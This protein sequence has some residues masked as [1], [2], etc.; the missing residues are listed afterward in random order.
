MVA[1][2]LAGSNDGEAFTGNTSTRL[3]RQRQLFPCR[4]AGEFAVGLGSQCEQANL[5]GGSAVH[6][7]AVSCL[8]TASTVILRMSVSSMVMVACVALRSDLGR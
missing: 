6:T 8:K 5:Q 3:C 7:L 4:H 1:P 2:A